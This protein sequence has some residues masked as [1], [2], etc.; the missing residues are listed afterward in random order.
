MKIK[1]WALYTETDEGGHS[2]TVHPTLAEAQ[3]EMID[4][5]LRD[6][7]DKVTARKFLGQYQPFIDFLITKV[8][9]LDS[10]TLESCEVE[11]NDCEK[12]F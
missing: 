7:A 6:R 9:G 12:V 11:V 1:M 10:W 5:L 3:H 4:D 8:R 2:L